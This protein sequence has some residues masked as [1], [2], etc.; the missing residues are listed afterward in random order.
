MA[1]NEVEDDMKSRYYHYARK[2]YNRIPQ[3]SYNK[4]AGIYADIPGE[5]RGKWKRTNTSFINKFNTISSFKDICDDIE[6]NYL[7]D[8]KSKANEQY[9][10]DIVSNLETWIIDVRNAYDEYKKYDDAAN[11]TVIDDYNLTPNPGNSIKFSSYMFIYVLSFLGL[12]LNLF[13]MIVVLIN[14]NSIAGVFSYLLAALSTLIYVAVNLIFAINLKLFK[15]ASILMVSISV[16]SVVLCASY[17]ASL[18]LT[19]SVGS[20]WFNITTIGLS[21]FSLVFVTFKLVVYFPR[22]T[23]KNG[24]II[25]NFSSLVSGDFDVKFEYSFTPK[26]NK[27]YIQIKKKK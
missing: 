5:S 23:N 27:N 21:L 19:N 18:S 16:L 26:T 14:K 15:R 10:K 20:I 17:F 24:T 22:N 25:G 11:K 9:D 13:E 3:V 7:S 12:S 2:K 6:L 4:I 8:L 1:K